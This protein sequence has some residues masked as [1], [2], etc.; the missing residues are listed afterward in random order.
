MPT[1]RDLIPCLRAEWHCE[2]TSAINTFGLARW[3]GV[4]SNQ[5]QG[6]GVD[7]RM[8]TQERGDEHDS[9]EPRT[10]PDY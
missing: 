8:G 1:T 5:C 9:V 3:H 6:V 7:T 4:T 2:S 10:R